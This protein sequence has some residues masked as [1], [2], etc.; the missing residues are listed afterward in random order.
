MMTDVL[1]VGGGIGGA[2]LALALGRCGWSVHVLERESSPTPRARPEILQESTLAALIELGVDPKL[3]DAA[4]PLHHIEVYKGD[5]TLLTIDE[6]DLQVADSHPVS[7]DPAII[8]AEVIDAAL[9]TGNVELVRGAEVTNI[10]RE[11]E[12]IVGVR[13]RREGRA[14]EARGRLLVGDDGAR[15]IIRGCLGIR[16]RLRLF[17]I[18]FVTFAVDRPPELPDDAALCWLRPEATRDAFFAGL[19]LPLPGDRTAGLLLASIGVWEARYQDRPDTFWADVERLNPTAA[20]LRGLLRFPDDFTRVRRT[21]GH[22]A[23]YV[24]DGAAIL[25]DAAHPMSPAG[26][27][28]ANAAVWDAIALADVA[29]EALRANDFSSRRL[30][31]YERRR[32]PA[33]R[34]SLWFTRRAVSFMRLARRIPGGGNLALDFLRVAA[35]NRGLIHFTATAFRDRGAKRR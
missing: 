26:G 7:T 33:N 31:E 17:P 8:R 3:Y 13:G 1:I 12:R 2:A 27:Q 19:V 4:L 9:A 5:E 35:R 15:S 34:R 28:S 10:I 29:D 30:A 20:T 25:G 24:A 22:A 18:E 21:Y 32:R 16:T 23:H 11:G 14:F 6:D